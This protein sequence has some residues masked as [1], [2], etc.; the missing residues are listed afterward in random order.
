MSYI[1]MQM[2]KFLEIQS[3]PVPVGLVLAR[4]ELGMRQVF[5]RKAVLFS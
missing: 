1:F 2:D 3:M 5:A 4:S